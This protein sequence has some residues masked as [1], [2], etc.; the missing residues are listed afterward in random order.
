MNP[1]NR[2]AYVSDAA[3]KVD[4][5]KLNA[6][7]FNALAS[8]GITPQR[9]SGTNF[10][11]AYGGQVYD[12]VD[13]NRLKE[14]GM[15]LSNIP[16][17]SSLAQIQDQA[18]KGSTADQ[19]I[20]KTYQ[21]FQGFDPTKFTSNVSAD[22]VTKEQSA[23]AIPLSGGRAALEQRLVNEGKPAPTGGFQTLTPTNEQLGRISTNQ[24]NQ[25]LS[26]PN[27]GVSPTLTRNAGE[28]IT[29][30]V[31]RVQGQPDVSQPTGGQD[32]QNLGIQTSA[33]A[34]VQNQSTQPTVA[35]LPQLPS[36]AEQRIQLRREQGIQNDESDLADLREQSAMIQ[37][38]LR[39]ISATAG[40][41]MTEAGRRGKMS[42]L[43]R[44]A[45]FKLEGLAIRESALLARINAKNSFID[46]VLDDQKSDYQTALQQWQINY[47]TNQD[48]VEA[49]NQQLNEDQKDAITTANTL[50]NLT[51]DS[52]L[53]YE[54]LPQDIRLQLETLSLRAGMP[55]TAFS[56][57]YT[58][59]Q[60]NEK[61]LSTSKDKNGFSVLYQAPDGTLRV[62][63]ISSGGTSSGGGS[64]TPTF[65]QYVASEQ[66]SN[67]NL[68]Q[69]SAEQS[70]REMA[71]LQA[72]YDKKYSASKT[73]A[74]LG[75][76]GLT[77]DGV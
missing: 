5:Y 74:G 33:S 75:S 31:K 28:S 64:A 42:E 11:P 76:Q 65:E 20:L 4:I 19:E 32:Y 36:T 61:I 7:D 49:L 77:Y 29:D 34:R 9:T 59:A 56:L 6:N 60:P 73:E 55:K 71:A 12:S 46:S 70:R 40:E 57:A 39:Q 10:Q 53:S 14:E 58:Q 21:F 22:V 52:G 37:Q 2:Q 63:R 23:A 25:V 66:Q 38:E 51:R 15:N 30:F 48:A 1:E 45:Q 69:T 68:F 62:E 50:L 54:Q 26:Q 18:S 17:R 47:K 44:D 72:Q 13:F 3:G 43:S 16:Y 27:M 8:S 24:L 41:R 35:G 67:P